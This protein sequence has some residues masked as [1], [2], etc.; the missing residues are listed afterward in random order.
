M[1]SELKEA[2]LE[3]IRIERK[4]VGQRKKL[5]DYLNRIVCMNLCVQD[6]C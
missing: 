6:K 5:G 4:E 2:D 3:K 1:I